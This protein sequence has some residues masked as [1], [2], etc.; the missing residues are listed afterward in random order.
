MIGEEQEGPSELEIKM[1]DYMADFRRLHK[2][3]EH[4]KDSETKYY[5]KL[6]QKDIEFINFII[7]KYSDLKEGERLVFDV[8]L[9]EE[10]ANKTKAKYGYDIEFIR[11]KTVEELKTERQ[12]GL[13][14]IEGL[15]QS[16]NI[17]EQIS[18]YISPFKSGDESQY[19]Q[20]SKKDRYS[21]GIYSLGI[22]Q[23]KL[24]HNDPIL[25]HPSFLTKICI[26]KPTQLT[27]GT[28]PIQ[29]RVK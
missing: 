14:S 21:P 18:I 23:P 27:P 19:L 8:D 5:Y 17:P 24:P 2:H 20:L 25:I 13:I 22:V 12:K 6:L 4:N 15:E 29:F 1:A 11:Q 3:N 9:S 28:Q 26:E 10:K 7:K 16:T